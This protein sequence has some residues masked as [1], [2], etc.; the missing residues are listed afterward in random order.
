M[1]YVPGR[2]QVGIVPRDLDASLAFYRDALALPYSGSRPALE[3]RTL[4]LF[5][6]GDVVI[7]LLE[8]PR[9]PRDAGVAGPYAEQSGIRW[10]TLDVDDLDTVVARCTD[11][12][13]A[14]QMPITE[15]RAGLRVAIVADP[16]GNAFEL[17][18]RAAATS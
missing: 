13:A 16:D 15:L 8:S 14:L 10:I 18:E 3:G 2:L 17:V 6:L 9:P 5:A 7:K 12:G 4:H 1:S 11:T